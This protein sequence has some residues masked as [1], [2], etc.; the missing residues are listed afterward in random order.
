M[1]ILLLVLLAAAVLPNLNAMREGRI[2]RAFPGDVRRLAMDARERAISDGRTYALTFGDQLQRL[3]LVEPSLE[4]GAGTTLSEVHLTSTA[5][6]GRLE[7]EGRE[8]NSADWVL[9]FYPDGSSDGGGVE[10]TRGNS[11]FALHVQAVNG[12]IRI[13]DGR[14]PDTTAQRWQAGDIERRL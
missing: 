3:Q 1:V 8:A 5:Q 4:G 13:I 7:L 10:F 12:T 9:N 14:L 2:E 6:T 11:V